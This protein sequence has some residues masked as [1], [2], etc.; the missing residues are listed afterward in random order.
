M[1]IYIDSKEIINTLTRAS[2]A[3]KPMSDMVYNDNGDVTVS[4]NFGYDNSL[5]A[6]WAQKRID[7]ALKVLTDPRTKG[8]SIT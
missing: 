6:Y 2:K 3:L 1:T 4:G 5:N 8:I 7:N